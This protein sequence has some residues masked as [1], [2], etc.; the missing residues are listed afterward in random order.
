[1]TQRWL[2]CQ[3]FFDLQRQHPNVP[4]CSWAPKRTRTKRYGLI[5]GSEQV[6]N[7]NDHWSLQ[8]CTSDCQITKRKRHQ[9]QIHDLA[10]EYSQIIQPLQ[11]AKQWL[12]HRPLM[13]LQLLKP[14]MQM[15]FGSVVVPG[16][17]QLINEYTVID[18]PVIAIFE[19]DYNSMTFVRLE[20]GTW[21]AFSPGYIT[22]WMDIERNQLSY[23][24]DEHRF[25]SFGSL[26]EI[27]IQIRG[28]Y[29]Q[30]TKTM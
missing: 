12:Y 4:R 2:S 26:D 18:H 28:E 24:Q 21:Q 8:R 14:F 17:A 13:Q 20:N 5:C 25:P 29:W 3:E 16:I 30:R 9:N 22:R 10:C 11:Y 15:I 6:V 27:L 7:P 19:A 1:M 23:K